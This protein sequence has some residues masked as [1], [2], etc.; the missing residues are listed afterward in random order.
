[1]MESAGIYTDARTQVHNTQKQR[2]RRTRAERLLSKKALGV[3]PAIRAAINALGDWRREQRGDSFPRE[4]PRLLVGNAF[5]RCIR[6]YIGEEE[7]KRKLYKIDM[8]WHET[9]FFLSSSSFRFL[10]FEGEDVIL[11]SSFYLYMLNNVP[12]KDPRDSSRILAQISS[13]GGYMLRRIR[14]MPRSLREIL[15]PVIE[16]NQIRKC[17]N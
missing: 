1:M 8:G 16:S 13:P 4:K 12:A 10:S 5:R 17:I 7:K 6:I 15:P 14:T 9:F 11:F 2:D 3:V